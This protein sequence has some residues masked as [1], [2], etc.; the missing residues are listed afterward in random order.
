M[1]KLKLQYFGH[2][3]EELTQWKGPS[4]WE[5]LKAG[6]EG[7]DS[8]WDGWMASLTQ[9]TWVWASS[10]SWWWTGKLGMLWSMR[11]QR[12][13]TTEQLN[14][15]KGN[16]PDGP[17]V[18]VL[19]WWLCGNESA[20]NTE[21]ASLIPRSEK[22]SRVGNGNPLQ[23]SCLG[24]LM[25]RET[26]QAAVYG[27]AKEL[28]T[29]KQNNHQQLRLRSSSA[30][31]MVSTPVQGTKIPH[32]MWHGPQIVIIIMRITEEEEVPLIPLD[33]VLSWLNT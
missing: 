3:L 24:N 33:V 21:E 12:S 9:W 1:L 10:G 29:T 23:Y 8:R 31:G 16:F 25:N 19:L 27:F 17:M 18:K 32:A 26:W 6:R 5:R 20:C 30:G 22:S 15:L 7:Y 2:W 4:C 28:D 13:G 11:L 14:W